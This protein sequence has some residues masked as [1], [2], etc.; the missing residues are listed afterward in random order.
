MNRQQRRAIAKKKLTDKDI[1]AMEEKT[2]KDA[3]DFAVTNYLACV[4]LCLHD[5]LGFGH[6][7]ACRFMRD[8]DNLFDSIN[9]GYLS[10]D[11]VLKTV[12]EEIGITFERTK[13]K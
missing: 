12:E 1:K 4:A 6:V 2:T 8:V 3:I 9:Q 7:R 5:K 11:D 13:Q 10:L